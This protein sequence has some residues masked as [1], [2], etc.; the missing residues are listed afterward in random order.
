VDAIH[1]KLRPL[2]HPLDSVKAVEEFMERFPESVTAFVE[3]TNAPKVQ[4]FIR[5]VITEWYE[6]MHIAFV[7]A[8]E[9][10]KKR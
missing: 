9:E 4:Q 2:Y 3:N 10:I 1:R 5:N 8:T 7:N 6:V